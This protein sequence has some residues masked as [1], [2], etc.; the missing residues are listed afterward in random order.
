MT[1]HSD[2][3][4]LSALFICRRLHHRRYNCGSRRSRRHERR[5]WRHRHG[6]LLPH[7]FPSLSPSPNPELLRPPLYCHR[8]C[9]P[10][11][12]RSSCRL[13]PIN[14][15]IRSIRSRRRT[16]MT[17]GRRCRQGATQRH[18]RRR[19]FRCHLPRAPHSR[20]R[21]PQRLYCQDI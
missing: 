8:D 9:R 20:R 13:R 10:R 1:T 11:R 7:P 15:R 16:R 4:P 21:I 5:F 12:A 18:L 3:S 19:L 17:R 14:Q 2:S 6:T